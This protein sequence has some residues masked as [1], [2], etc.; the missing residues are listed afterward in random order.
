MRRYR[1]EEHQELITPLEVMAD[2]DQEA[3]ERAIHQ[4]EHVTAFETQYGDMQFV[5]RSVDG[6]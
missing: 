1:F 5:L 2:S 6:D 4:D 3:R